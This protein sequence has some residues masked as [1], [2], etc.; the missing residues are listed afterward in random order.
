MYAAEQAL[1]TD[2]PQI[3]DDAI[4]D[5]GEIVRPAH[6]AVDCERLAYP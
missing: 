3:R 4:H 5:A 1:M 2:D 6:R